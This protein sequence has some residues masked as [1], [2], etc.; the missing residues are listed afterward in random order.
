VERGYWNEEESEAVMQREC[1]REVRVL[2]DEIA[3]ERRHEA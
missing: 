2:L 3:R 1:V